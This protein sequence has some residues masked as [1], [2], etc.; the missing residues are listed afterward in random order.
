MDLIRAEIA[1]AQDRGGEAPML[2]LR[3]AQRLSP[4][5][6][7]LARDTYLEAWAAALFAGSLAAAGGSLADV[8]R[9]A[10][11]APAPP[12]PPTAADLLLD[13]LSLVFTAGRSA[14]G[15]TLRRAVAAFLGPDASPDET[16]RWGWLA[17][18]AANFV[19]DDV[20]GLEIA[21]RAVRLARESGALE[22]LG[23]ADNACGQAAAFD[24]DFATARLLIAEVDAVKDAT[25]TRI[26]TA[27]GD[28]P[29]GPSRATLPRP[30]R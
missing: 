6:P 20:G 24:G 26:A 27:C 3:A 18:R 2:L 28:R 19:W 1:F 25:G 13:A 7:R 14:A 16:L 5:D 4:L 22:A 10:A 29:G 17:S 21:S 23:V 11:D 30:S 8:S 12:G 9:A 15:P